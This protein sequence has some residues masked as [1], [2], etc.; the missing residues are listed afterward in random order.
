MLS[1]HT[2]HIQ[3][4][5]T[6]S[7]QAVDVPPEIQ[8]ARL[9]TAARQ[10]LESRRIHKIGGDAEADQRNGH[11]E[12]EP[13]SAEEDAAWIAHR[14]ALRSV[15]GEYTRKMRNNGDYPE[16]VLVTVKSTIRDV[17]APMIRKSVL[18]K[19]VCDAAQWSIAAYFETA[20]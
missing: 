5:G 17:G 15:V 18:D 14:R 10:A 13:S 12:S 4:L 7:S 11:R 16:K 19:L 8:L 3:P 1:D 9:A 20:S 6:A 2:R